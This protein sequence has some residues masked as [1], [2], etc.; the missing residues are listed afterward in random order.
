MEVGYLSHALARIVYEGRFKK[1]EVIK[2]S[3][4]TNIFEVEKKKN[5]GNF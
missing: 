3:R 2:E 5:E 4:Y 1:L